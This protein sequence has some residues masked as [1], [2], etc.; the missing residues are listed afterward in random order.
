MKPSDFPF[1]S[2][3]L[4]PFVCDDLSMSWKKGE[5]V[6]LQANGDEY[7]IRQGDSV[8][9]GTV[10]T[11]FQHRTSSQVQ[12]GLSLWVLREQH[13]KIL[14]LQWLELVEQVRLDMAIGV[15]EKIAEDLA[16]KKEIP[17]AEVETAVAWLNEH[18]IAQESI[19]GT[20]SGQVFL[21]RYGN[22]SNDSFVLFG[23]GWRGDIKR[24]KGALK[25]LRI[26]RLQTPTDSLAMAIGR[27]EFYDDSVARQLQS[28]E[29]R[30]QLDTAIRDSGNYLKLWQEYGKLEY[31][32][33]HD[34]AKE[35]G[36]LRYNNAIQGNG[37][38]KDWEL[39]ANHEQLDE[40]KKRWKEIGLSSETQV[41]IGEDE[42]DLVSMDLDDKVNEYS[43]PIRGKL[44]FEHDS[45]RFVPDQNRRSEAP[46]KKG[47][48]YYSLAGDE[49]VRKRRDRAKESIDAGRRL[50]Q[51]RY[52]LEGVAPPIARLRRLPG[53]TPY[54]KAC[55][56]GFPTERQKDALDV[57]LNTPDIALIVGPPG[58]GKTQVIAALQRRLA[59][60][61][62]DDLQ[63]QVLIS[64]YQ[65]DAVDN[66][67]NRAEIFGLPAIRVGGRGHRDESD[68]DPV[69]VWCDRKHKEVAG[70]L[71]VLQKEE[72]L[73]R[74]LSE[75]D[76]QI[77]ALRLSSLSPAERQRAFEG[78]N[79]LLRELATLGVRL[80][81]EIQDR[82]DE[83]LDR[84]TRIE[85]PH[86]VDTPERRKF[87]RYL[88][89]LRTTSVGF[90]DDGADR[91][92]QVEQMLKRKGW[93]IADA[94]WDLLKRLGRCDEAT[95]ADLSA[96]AT[97]KNAML[98]RWLPDYR[99]PQL[100]RLL[101]GDALDMLDAIVHAIKTPLRESQRGI[102]AVLASY[103]ASL[104]QAPKETE[105][106]VREYASIVGATCQQ[107]AGKA[108]SNLKNLSNLDATEDIEFD[109]VI[110]DEAARANPLDLFVPMAMA[111]RRI[112]LVGD[113]RQLPHL[114]QKDLEDELV[115]KQNLNESQAKAYEQ[116]LFE[117]LVKQ[118]RGQEKVDGV[119]RVVMLDTQFRMHPTLGDF[120]S[121]QFY[122]T[123]GLDILRSGRAPDDFAHNVP[124]YQGKCAAW[125]DVPL[126]E[127]KEER[128]GTSRIRQAEAKAI[129]KE[130]KHILDTCEPTLS[131]GVISFYRAQS[132]LILDAFNQY[133]LAEEDEGKMRIVQNYRQTPS[134]EERL[135]VGTVDAFQGKEF[136]VVFLSIVRASDKII[137]E[138]KTGIER[139]TLLNQK[140][141][142]LRLANRLNVAMSRQRKLLIAVGDKSMVE[143][144]EAEASI[145]AL[146]AFLR[147]CHEEKEH[148]R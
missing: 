43:H 10:A 34:T 147:L 55:F 59:E 112:V 28:E 84:N 40:F 132:N 12:R 124:G 73:T 78:I 11:Q 119:R 17:A 104:V 76:R 77:A 92:Y 63:H 60:T 38:N 47:F 86:L 99:P 128:L 49:A 81:P 90:G 116:S 66:A 95:D 32:Q 6:Q 146:A 24:D 36:F 3:E 107:A 53:L 5:P 82:W 143:G 89:A 19:E 50:S 41:E 26:T 91:V 142:H 138:Q 115:E 42:P 118:L 25:L 64:S 134:G 148:G 33:A 127:G 136:D 31:K 15:N 29:Q 111:R 22:S 129:A 67:L 106:A 141:G 133:G 69:R 83:F 135:R 88:R 110:I 93:D 7:I 79:G 122:E 44:Q 145:P 102:T 71:D 70:R 103:C 4:I 23:D 94:E 30:A 125:L 140:Y 27:I 58:T 130:V 120:I 20:Q 97:F 65:H 117:R 18:F 16:A 114:V 56:K 105:R 137:P 51:L 109:T 100:K 39:K 46:P 123:E 98:D 45:L 101:D 131:I 139:E 35:L 61:L 1:L 72:P 80:L 74:P 144:G 9:A 37:E 57:A 21:G 48:I 14:Q 96:L 121:R 68:I 87:I 13:D 113:H 62:G 8:C 85:T 108:M 75:L 126:H 2:N 54:A 52:L